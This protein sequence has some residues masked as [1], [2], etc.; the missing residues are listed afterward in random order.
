MKGANE[1]RF[2]PHGSTETLLRDSTSTREPRSK[3]PPW[4][5]WHCAAPAHTAT[6]PPSMSHEHRQVPGAVLAVR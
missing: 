2:Q 1:K 6:R 5:M 3:C 4:S